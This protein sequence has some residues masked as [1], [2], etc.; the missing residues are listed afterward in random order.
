M[1]LVLSDGSEFRGCSFGAYKKSYGEVV[2]TTTM[3]GYPEALTD[4][5]YKG[6]ILI[7]TH[8]MVGNYGVP[9]KNII[10]KR[11][12]LPLHFESDGIKV[13]GLVVAWAT[14]PSHWASERSLDEWLK[15]EGVPG[16]QFVD[17]RK[18]VKKLREEGV[19]MGAI[20][21]ADED[22]LSYLENKP[23]YDE[24]DFI[25]KVRPKEVKVHGEGI[26]VGLLDCGVKYGIVRELTDRGLKVIRIPCGENLDKYISEIKGIVLAN[27]PG[28]PRIVIDRYN[29]DKFAKAAIEYKIPILAICL[30]HQILNIALGAEVYKMKYGHRGVNKPVRDEDS[31]CY[32][33]SENHGF[34]IRK[35]SVNRMYVK[36]W[37]FNPDDKTLEGVRGVKYPILSVQFHP[38][39]S[40]GPND[41]KWIFDLFKREIEK[42]VA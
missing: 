30:G 24:V 17:T 7:I 39:S 28:N 14:K 27:G 32:I 3:Y 37:F 13:E 38:E 4:P 6:Q 1:K 23:K 29:V 18:L 21:P 40:P 31:K 19:Q 42:G 9:R 33:V 20:V 34:A 36:P 12:H 35:E 5:S 41:T 26:P 22:G 15:E 8:P 25:E 11:S 16:I 10:H 2:F